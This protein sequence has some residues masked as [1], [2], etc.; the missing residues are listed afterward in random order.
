MRDVMPSGRTRVRSPGESYD[1]PREGSIQSLDSQTLHAPR[2][3]SDRPRFG[4]HERATAVRRPR[5]TNR[6][7][8][9][10]W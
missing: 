2:H 3:F 9:I 4:I 5:R 8:V 6:A 7:G 10:Q 1:M